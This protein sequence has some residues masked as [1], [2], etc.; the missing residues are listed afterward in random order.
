VTRN[1]I[2]VCLV[3]YSIP[4]LSYGEDA[5]KQEL[6]N[7][8][9]EA[10]GM[11]AA[12]D[13]IPG[14]IEAQYEQRKATAKDPVAEALV[15]KIFLKSFDKEAERGVLSN[16]ISNKLDVQD[17]KAITGW[18][19]SPLG[20]RFTSA[21]LAASSPESRGEL[22]R[23]IADMK[24]NPPAQDRIALIQRFEKSARQTEAAMTI[25]ES[26][27]RGMLS[28]VSDF[29]SAEKKHAEEDIN[30]QIG[31]MKEATQQKLRQQMVLIS[32]YTYRKFSNA[33]I[34]KY[35][36][37]LDSGIGKKY[38]D[39]TIAGYSDVLAHYIHVVLPKIKRAAEALKAKE[40]QA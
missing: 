9:I 33:E 6:V 36:G 2:I 13:S 14:Q 8:I 3:L 20:K 31:E 34:E 4:W 11:G 12:I 39:M 23:Y 30:K 22:V 18:L 37:F 26:I 24:K 17:M 21:E 28:G 16:S 5:Q 29:S 7:K 25:L 40:K 10:S 1:I 27:M 35:I 32:H 19:E 15:T 38:V